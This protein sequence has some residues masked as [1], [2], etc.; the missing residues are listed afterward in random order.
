L[1]PSIPSTIN[2][3]NKMPN[4]CSIYIRPDRTEIDRAIAEKQGNN[5]DIARRFNVGNDKIPENV[6][7]HHAHHSATLIASQLHIPA[8]C[9]TGTMQPQQSTP[10]D[11]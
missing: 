6:H 3:E 7:M 8:L 10:A 11:S 5:R 9:T 2:E 4:V 1:D